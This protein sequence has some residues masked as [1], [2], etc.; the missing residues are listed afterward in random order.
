M[1]MMITMIFDSNDNCDDGD[2]SKDYINDNG[3]YV[4]AV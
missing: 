2:D 3:D 1:R 4:V